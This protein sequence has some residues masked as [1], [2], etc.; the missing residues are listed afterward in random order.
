MRLVH[1]ASL[2]HPTRVPYAPVT[3]KLDDPPEATVVGLAAA[4]LGATGVT[5]TSS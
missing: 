5:D 4:A 2:Y 1:A 3:E